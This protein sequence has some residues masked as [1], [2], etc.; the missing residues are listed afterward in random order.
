MYVHSWL[1]SAVAFEDYAESWQYMFAVLQIMIGY[2][3][4]KI[5]KQSQCL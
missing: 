1:W 3:G 4:Y 5:R 2:T